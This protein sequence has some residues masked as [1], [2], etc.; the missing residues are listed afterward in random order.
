MNM[1]ISQGS[2]RRVWG[3]VADYVTKASAVRF[4]LQYR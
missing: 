1:Q 2:V 3:E 4:R